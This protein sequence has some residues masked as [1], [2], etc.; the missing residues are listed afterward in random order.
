VRKCAVRRGGESAE[1][2]LADERQESGC[3]AMDSSR[4]EGAMEET[5]K[6]EQFAVRERVA[7]GVYMEGRRRDSLADVCTV[8]TQTRSPLTTSVSDSGKR[9]YWD[10]LVLEGLGG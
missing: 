1:E 7:S 8:S 10:L 9:L 4:S 3:S 6:A 2:E 5:E